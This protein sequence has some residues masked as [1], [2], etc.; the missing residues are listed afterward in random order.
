[1]SRGQNKIEENG[2]AG[3]SP[4]LTWIRRTGLFIRTR[5]ASIITALNVRQSADGE[6]IPISMSTN[7]TAARVY[8]FEGTVLIIQ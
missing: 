8:R 1:M 5:P 7:A 2:K 6:R 3:G 4:W